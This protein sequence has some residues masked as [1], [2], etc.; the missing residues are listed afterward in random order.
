[1]VR[2]AHTTW[3]QALRRGVVSGSIA[4]IASATA[5]AA[6]GKRELDDAAAPLN[7]PSQWLWGEGAACADGFSAR[8]TVAGYLV[9]HA[10][11]VF[12]AVLYEKFRRHPLPS[13]AAALPAI[14]TSAGACFVDY[15]LTPKRL[16]PGFEKRL[17]RGSLLLVYGAFAA[18]LAVSALMTGDSSRR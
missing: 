6:C 15:C 10:M 8:H 16:T 14:A 18:G 4:S 3:K 11:S 13:A 12:W 7:G 9:H 2:M 17:S 1:M 5:L